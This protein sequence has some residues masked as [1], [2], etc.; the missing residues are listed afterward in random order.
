MLRY[1]E[2]PSCFSSA[3]G[4]GTVFSLSNSINLTFSKNLSKQYKSYCFKDASWVL[5]EHR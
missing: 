1:F 3:K 5:S 4:V 2:T